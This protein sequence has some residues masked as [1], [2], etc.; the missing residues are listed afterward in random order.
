VPLSTHA[1]VF[2]QHRSW[3]WRA[4]R[5]SIGTTVG[6]IVMAMLAKRPRIGPA[7]GDGCD[8]LID[9]DCNHGDR[10]F[11][12]IVSP[13]RRNG[14]WGK[15]EVV[16]TVISVRDNLRMLADHLKLSDADRIAMFA[17]FHKWIHKD[18]RARSEI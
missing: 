17:E 8:I 4:V 12:K 7:F 6:L 14:V 5:A 2:D 15:A 11:C 3:Q 18:Y 1:D 10:C 9:L 16:G 13:V